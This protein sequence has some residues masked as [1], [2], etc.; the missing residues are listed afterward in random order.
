MLL[1]VSSLCSLFTT[2]LIAHF[3]TKFTTPDYRKRL[4][5]G[6]QFFVVGK[7]WIKVSTLCLAVLMDILC[8]L[9]STFSFRSRGYLVTVTRLWAGRPAPRFFCFLL[10]IC[11]QRGHP[12][13]YPLN[14]GGGR[15]FPE[16]KA[17]YVPTLISL[18][19][20]GKSEWHCVST[21]PVKFV[22]RGA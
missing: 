12:P 10:R 14:T 5:C 3:E 13:S 20:G 9:V 19:T 2:V 21:Y 15:L 4:V 7:F 1:M 8:F 18:N 17:C 6:R 22:C 11:G 16:I